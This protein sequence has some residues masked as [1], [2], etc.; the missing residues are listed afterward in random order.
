[1]VTSIRSTT[2]KPLLAFCILCA[3]AAPVAAA[4]LSEASPSYV[5]PAAAPIVWTGFYTG[6]NSRRAAH[7]HHQLI[8]KALE[9]QMPKRRPEKRGS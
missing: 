5:S 2:M 8:Q 9:T 7:R 3:T 1:M 6:I 4:D